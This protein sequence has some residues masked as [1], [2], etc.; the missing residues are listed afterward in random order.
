MSSRLIVNSI[1][2]T[3]ASSDAITFDNAGKCAFPNNTGNILQVV[4]VTKSDTTSLASS[5]WH[6]ISGLQPSIT[7]SSA[8]NK[9]LIQASFCIG[10]SSKSADTPL[11]LFRSV[12]GSDTDI[13]IGDAAGNRQR[14]FW[15]TEDWFGNNNTSDGAEFI[16][17]S[18]SANF[19]DSPNTTSAITYGVNWRIQ[20]GHAVYLNR[21]GHDADNTNYPRG[22]STITLM[23]VAA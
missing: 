7:P 3:G 19:L 4:S 11:K 8:S 12:G 18:A 20:S 10:V 17:A 22:S 23:E 1:R 21:T 2:H 6:K 15:G 14:C 13:G 5:S 9:I 16:M